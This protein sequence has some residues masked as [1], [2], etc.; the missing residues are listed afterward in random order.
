MAVYEVTISFD[1]NKVEDGVRQDF[2]NFSLGYS[3]LDLEGVVMLEEKGVALV[4]DLLVLGKAKLAEK[5]AAE[6]ALAPT[7]IAVA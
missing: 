7:A 3:N 5:K 6:D 1:I 2:A 4:N